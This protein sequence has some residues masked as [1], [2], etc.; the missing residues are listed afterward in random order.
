M[1]ADQGGVRQA[2]ELLDVLG[3]VKSRVQDRLGI[4]DFPMPQFILIGSQSVGKS[5]LVEAFAGEQFNFCSGTLGSRRPT[6][7]E[8]R[9]VQTVES[10]WYYLDKATNQWQHKS[11]AEVN[12]WVGKAHNELGSSVSSEAIYVRIES[13]HCVDMQI[14]D[15]PG[16]RGFAIDG[17]AEALA[18]SIETLNKQFLMDSRNVVLCVEEAGDAANCKSLAKVREFDPQYKRTILIRNKLDK[19]YGDLTSDNVNQWLGGFGDLP[20]ELKKFALTLPHW[21]DGQPIPAGKTLASLRDEAN[22]ADVNK[23]ASLGTSS[24]FLSQVGFKNFAKYMEARIERMFQEALG[25]VLSKLRELED[26]MVQR[27]EDLADELENSDPQQ[28]LATVRAAGMS[29]ANCLTYVMEGY[30]R[31]DINRLTLDDEL[32]EF[33][34]FHETLGDTD[35]FLQLPSQDFAD[36]DDYIDYLRRGVEVPAFEV[37]INGGAQFR[38]LMFEVETFLRFSEI[39]IETKKRDVLQSMGIA[40][41]SIGWREVI[42][43]LLNHDA[44]LPLQQRVKYVGERIKWF[45]QQQKEPIVQFMKTLKGSPDEKLYSH[46][47]SKHAKLIEDNGT[48]RKL[49]FDTFDTVVQRQLEQFV[50]LFKS[51]LH[52]TFANPWVFLKKTTA[53]LEDSE[54]GEEML[55][56][57]LEDTKARI[58]QEIKSRSGI[59]RTVTKWIYDIPQEPHHIDTAVDKVQLLVLKVYS[60]IRSQVCDQVELFAE[61]FFKLPLCRRLEE[62]MSHIELS[63]VDKEG[64]R[65]RREKLDKDLKATAFGLAEVQ[66]CLKILQNFSLKQSN[67]VA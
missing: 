47:Y 39:G 10:K 15:L 58:P 18:A 36:L 51:T 63:E 65:A 26:N 16:Y 52:A 45:F 3:Q 11:M 32:R 31:S 48:I 7:L 38:R 41:N 19:Y 53:R 27:K 13:K 56:P 50:D 9:N 34:R 20:K 23:L 12:E 57:S 1:A 28:M 60:H 44:H 59:E 42:V 66:D 64:Y 67:S 17:K 46:L 33:H 4:V 6:V 2:S 30:I 21:Q 22:A 55:L 24:K 49:V 37:A 29:F 62:D 61:S 8:F 35:S 40:M 14:V 54:I 25:P 43:K 5:R